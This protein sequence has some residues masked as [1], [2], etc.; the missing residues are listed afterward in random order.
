M[1]TGDHISTARAIAVDV[2]IVPRHTAHLSKREADA[3]VMTASQFDKMSEEEIDDLPQLPLVIARCS[4]QTKVRLIEALHRRGLY[5]AMTGDGVN[6][7][8]SLKQADVGIAMG[9]AGSDVAKDASDIVLTDDNFASI[10]NAIEEGRRMADNIKRFVLHLLAQN[11]AQACVLLIGL[12]FKDEDPGFSV[13]PLSPIEVIWIIMITSGLPAMGL[14][15]QPAEEDVMR[16]PPDDL[17]W[18][19]FAPEV[20]VDTVVYGFWMAALVLATFTLSLFGFGPSELGMNCNRSLAPGDGCENVYRAR[21]ACFTFLTWASVLLAWEVVSMRRSFFRMRNTHP[22]WQQW[23]V[24][25]YR[26]KALFYS[27]VFALVTVFP[28]LY[29]PGLN[30]YIFLHQGISWEWAIVIVCVV[31]FVMGIEAWKWG[32]R[33]YF[34]RH[35]VDTVRAAD[36]EAALD[37]TPAATRAKNTPM[38]SRSQT[39]E[40]ANGNAR[41]GRPMEDDLP[42]RLSERLTTFAE[43]A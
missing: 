15:L 16:R 38:G 24:D 42:R 1:A 5:A 14:G 32:K 35:E 43:K 31:L 39:L 12:A 4:P 26:N 36:E 28:I 3:L 40:V 34:R 11:I 30:R 19:L 10:P 22:I 41:M 2:G 29:I 20:M 17:K 25:V 23:A 37:K 33:V 8:P 18:G 7:S 13:F 21:G 9:Q 27:V 6:D